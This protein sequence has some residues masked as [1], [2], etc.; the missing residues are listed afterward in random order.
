MDGFGCRGWLIYE[1]TG[2]SFQ[3]DLV[4]GVQALPILLL[5]PIAGSTADL[6][7]RTKA[8]TVCAG[9]GWTVVCRSRHVDRYGGH[10]GM[11]Y[12]CNLNRPGDR[13]TFQQPSRASV[14]LDA[15]PPGSLINAIGLKRSF[16][17]SREPAAPLWRAL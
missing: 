11:A 10:S 1:L 9:R 8:G 17:M 5:S 7:A 14:I 16:S 12:L 2:S 6:Y 15:V 4:R 13:Q 3:L